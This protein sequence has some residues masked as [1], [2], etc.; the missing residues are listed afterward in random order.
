MSRESRDRH[1]WGDMWPL[2]IVPLT[3]AIKTGDQVKDDGSGADL[4]IMDSTTNT[5]FV[6]VAMQDSAAANFDAIRVA[7][8]GIFEFDC[9]EASFAPG[10]WVTYDTNAQTV[11]AGSASDGIGVVW[12]LG[13]S[14]TRVLVKIDTRL[15][16]GLPT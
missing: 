14:V 8:E 4:E 12:K 5:T 16:F 13:S 7:T 3:A 9:A 2:Y 6:G 10:D 11:V 1:K 15:R